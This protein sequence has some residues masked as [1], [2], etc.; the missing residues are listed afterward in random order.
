MF[1]DE[2]KTI[3][4]CDADPSLIFELLKEEHIAII[5]K[6]LSRKS[7]DINVTDID[8]NNIL[9]KLLKKGQFEIVLKHIKDKRWDINHQNNEGDTFSHILVAMK[10]L[11]VLDIYKEIQ[12]NKDFIP[13]VR[14]NNGETILDI[15][16]KSNSTFMTSK[17]LEDSRFNEVGVVSF[18]NF[19]DTYIKSSTYGKYTRIS[20]L[21]MFI[22]YLKN[23]EVSPKVKEIIS[24]LKDNF[25]ASGIGDDSTSIGI[26]NE[27]CTIEGCN[28]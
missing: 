2:T 25:D 5:D 23:K 8:G 10:G 17:I 26:T 22:D 28:S 20:N 6:I 1:Y 14:N 18:K 7:F 13:N 9:T 12:K 27:G 11:N 4:A 21:E 16:I 19:Y 24:Y 15:A 3:N